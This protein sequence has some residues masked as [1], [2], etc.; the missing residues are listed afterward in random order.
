[1]KQSCIAAECSINNH[2]DHDH[3][4]TGLLQSWSLIIKSV[5]IA[6]TGLPEPLTL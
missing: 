1:L 2:S 4:H 6:T 5:N 3:D